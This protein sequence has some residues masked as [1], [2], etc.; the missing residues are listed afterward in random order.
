M[1]APTFVYIDKYVE[2]INQP[3][4]TSLE[5]HSTKTLKMDSEPWDEALLIEDT[6]INIS[7]IDHK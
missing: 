5:L 3:T 2:V 7:T 6:S 1:K 4:T